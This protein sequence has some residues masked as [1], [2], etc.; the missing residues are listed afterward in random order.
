[1][2]TR[3]GKKIVSG[4]VVALVLLCCDMAYSQQEK[5]DIEVLIFSAGFFADVNG[6]TVRS[7]FP[8][9]DFESTT[10]SRGFNVGGSVGYFL[11]RRNELG[12]GLNLSVFNTDS[13]AG[14]DDD[15]R[16]NTSVGLG[17]N[18]FYR[19][20]FAREGAKGFPFIGSDFLVA[21]VTANSTGNLIA[22]PQVGYKYF[23]KG[24]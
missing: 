21:D 19:Y 5:G 10:R 14:D 18:G 7:R 17:L 13:C 20:N 15:C 2:I 1:M 6:N 11:T 24:M 4:F 12:G 22:R 9:S 23:S 3:T 16:D 8:D